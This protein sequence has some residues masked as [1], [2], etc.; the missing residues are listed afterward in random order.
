[1]AEQAGCAADHH[2]KNDRATQ[3]PSLYAL[4]AWRGTTLCLYI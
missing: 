3:L 1:V 2:P 4:M